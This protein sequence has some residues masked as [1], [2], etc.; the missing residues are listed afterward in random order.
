[1]YGSGKQIVLTSDKAPGA[2]AGLEQRLRS[3]FEAG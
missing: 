1:L 2:I 3:R